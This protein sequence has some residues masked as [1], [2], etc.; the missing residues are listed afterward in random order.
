M[1]KG[2]GFRHV[3]MRDY[4]HGKAGGGLTGSRAATVIGFWRIFG[5]LFG[6]ELKAE[7]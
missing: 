3:L 1:K 7:A 4:W 2:K 6:S 5:L